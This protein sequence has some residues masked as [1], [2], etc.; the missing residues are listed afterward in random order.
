[1]W[2]KIAMSLKVQHLKERYPEVLAE[3]VLKDHKID[4][5]NESTSDNFLPHSSTQSQSSGFTDPSSHP[6]SSLCSQAIAGQAARGTVLFY[7]L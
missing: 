4:S 5:P 1:M 3:V 7:N 6:L 2:N